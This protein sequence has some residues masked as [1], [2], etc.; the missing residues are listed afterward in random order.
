M[1]QR[2]LRSFLRKSPGSK[3]TALEHKPLGVHIFV[4]S[5]FVLLMCKMSRGNVE[6]WRAPV[7][8]NS[9][10]L[11]KAF[12]IKQKDGFTPLFLGHFC[13]PSDVIGDSKPELDEVVKSDGHYI[14]LQKRRTQQV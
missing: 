8:R 10:P 14:A 7:T 6:T 13:T 1:E 3:A 5:G 9:N 12:Q 4:F 11:S 2:E